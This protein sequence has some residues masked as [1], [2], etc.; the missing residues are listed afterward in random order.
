MS[1]EQ[2]QKYGSQASA[3]ARSWSQHCPEGELLNGRECHQLL[4]SLTDGILKCCQIFCDSLTYWNGGAPKCSCG[5][6]LTE[7]RTIK[8]K[9]NA[10]HDPRQ[11]SNL[12]V[13]CGVKWLAQEHTETWWQAWCSSLDRLLLVPFC[14][15]LTNFSLCFGRT[16]GL[17]ERECDLEETGLAGESWEEHLIRHSQA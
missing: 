15:H 9:R 12:R 2:S 7:L 10:T 6:L 3:D 11:P 1:D 17:R 8:G 14:F 4:Y 16:T 13:V 5:I